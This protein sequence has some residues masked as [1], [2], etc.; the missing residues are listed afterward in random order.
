MEQSRPLANIPDDVLLRRLAELLRESRRVESDLVEHI[1]EVDARRLYAREA[2]PS[3]FAYCTEVLHLSEAEAYL[4]IAVARASRHHPVLLE[5]L[6]D[7]RLHLTGIAKLAPILTADNR[8]A[9]LERAVHKSKREIE[10][11]VAEVAPRPDA[12]SSIR[13]LPDRA[14]L[15]SRSD[16]SFGHDEGESQGGA[17]DSAGVLK[18]TGELPLPQPSAPT[19]Q[20]LHLLCPERVSQYSAEA[21]S[22]AAKAKPGAIEPSA[23][24][25]YRV[26]FTASTELRNKIERLRALMRPQI[27]DGDLAAVI[28]QAVTEKLL[29]IEAR[30]FATTKRP[31]N[32]LASADEKA[33]SRHVPAVVRRAIRERQGEQCGFVDAGGRCCSERHRLEYHHRTRSAW[34]KPPAVEHGPLVSYAQS[35]AGRARLWTRRHRTKAPSPPIAGQRGS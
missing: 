2:A 1:A 19:A 3:M 32:V 35:L 26:Q 31:R 24:G 9:L 11:L 27:P 14:G 8:D 5:L 22:G 34:W 29:R 17:L 13:F 15:M 21:V 16:G 20:A 18:P 7:G 28:E 23:P 33:R 10:V 30:R 4:R 25:R 12:R 6:R